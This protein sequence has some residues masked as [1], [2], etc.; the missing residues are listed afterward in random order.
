MKKFSSFTFF[1]C[2]FVLLQSGRSM[3]T[4][5]HQQQ[6]HKANEDPQCALSQVA[7]I[8]LIDG[9]ACWYLVQFNPAWYLCRFTTNLMAVCIC[10]HQLHNHF[11]AIKPICMRDW[12]IISQV[13]PWI[14][15][16]QGKV[17]TMIALVAHWLCIYA[18]LCTIIIIKHIFL[19]RSCALRTCTC[20]GPHF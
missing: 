12:L 17:L 1:G 2:W 11:I 20:Q 13:L 6:Q 4:S 18:R 19:S 7:I 3:T 15:K 9:V 10:I 16:D 5:A 14:Q 8:V